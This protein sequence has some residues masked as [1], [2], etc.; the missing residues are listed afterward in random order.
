[1]AKIL[2]TG[3]NGFV[4][5]ALCDSLR[6]QGINVIAAVRRSAYENEYE[7]G[8]ISALTDWIPALE[9]C[10]T[11]IHLAARV[12]V[13]NEKN[14]NPLA[15][16]RA[17]N[18]DATINL[19]RQAA[20]CN[21]ERFIFIS[22]I[23]VNGAETFSEPFSEL[24]KPQPHS[25][26]ALSKFEA[27]EGVK[28]ICAQSSM[29]F[30]IIRPPLIYG[31]SAPGNFKS[32]LKFVQKGLFLPLSLVKNQRSMVALDNLVNFIKVC[33]EHPKAANQTFLVSDGESISTPQLIRLLSL[34]MGKPAR[35]FP[36]PVC[37]LKL[38]AF[39]LGRK[40]MYQQLCGSLQIDITK[41]QDLLGWIPPVHMNDGLH[42]AAERYLS[43]KII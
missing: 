4:G 7:V 37:I 28:D 27:E 41:A 1:M 17:V 24:S 25:D 40:V 21:V 11:V 43:E 22:S 29:K 6:E 9:G 14:I 33:I 35:L 38:G 30:V 2:V 15:A 20:Q 31:S 10:N 18:V 5:S 36:L 8:S 34:C 26:Y 19:A 13:M 39:L 12:H 3:A 23:G 32:L 42:D 16:F